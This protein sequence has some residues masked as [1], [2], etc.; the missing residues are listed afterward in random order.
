MKADSVLVNGNI[1]SIDQDNSTYQALAIK[2]SKIIALG[3]DEEIDQYIDFDTLILD[4]E[5]RTVT[6]GFVDCHNHTC[7]YGFSELILDLRYPQVQSIEDI[8]KLV[9]QEAESKPEG[10][11]V[12]GVGWDDALLEE[13][14]PPT[15]QDLDPVSPYNPRARARV[16]V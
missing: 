10:T 11:W 15:R 1:I 13:N 4:L 9:K 16:L 7:E 5:D 8:V 2:G 3:S 14:R 12:R 6:P